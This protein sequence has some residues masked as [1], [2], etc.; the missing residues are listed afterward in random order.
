LAWFVKLLTNIDL[1]DLNKLFYVI[2]FDTF[3]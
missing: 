1:H 3:V 2:I